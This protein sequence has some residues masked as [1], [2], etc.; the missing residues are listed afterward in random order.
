MSEY[1]YAYKQQTW[2]TTGAFDIYQFEE[3]VVETHVKMCRN[4]GNFIY[5][6]IWLWHLGF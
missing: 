1:K 6:C 5:V 4:V 3:N 2:N